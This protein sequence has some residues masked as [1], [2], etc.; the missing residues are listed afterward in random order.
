[1]PFQPWRSSHPTYLDLLILRG[2]HI[3]RSDRCL[4]QL[5][6]HKLHLAEEVRG[7]LI[8]WDLL[9]Y[10]VVGSAPSSSRS[11][12]R[13]IWLEMGT[14]KDL[15][16]DVVMQIKLRNEAA[17]ALAIGVW[18]GCAGHAGYLLPGEAMLPAMVA[19]TFKDAISPAD[20]P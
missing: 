11:C 9:I 14:A 12:M 20:L 13:C 5:L 7:R 6:M 18:L 4:V 16:M 1:M 15:C 8:A 10:E 2:R 19:H 17:S 3:L